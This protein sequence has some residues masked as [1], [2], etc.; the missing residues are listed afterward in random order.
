MPP[1]G[2]DTNEPQVLS[3]GLVYRPLLPVHQHVAV[4]QPSHVPPPP[5][6]PGVGSG[7]GSGAGGA[8]VSSGWSHAVRPKAVHTS[9]LI[10]CAVGVPALAIFCALHS[11]RWPP[12]ALAYSTRSVTP[13]MVTSWR[14]LSISGQASGGTS[15]PRATA[16]LGQQARMLSKDCVHWKPVLSG[17]PAS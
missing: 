7:A 2:Q 12:L 17:L 9:V 8:V 15:I 3:K 10:C 4:V 11:I 13:A 6:V 14:A 5:G 1:L 16:A